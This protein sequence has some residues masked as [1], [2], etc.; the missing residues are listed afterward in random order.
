MRIAMFGGSFNPVHIGHRQLAEAFAKELKL[1][2][3]IVMPAY[4]SPF[5]QSDHSI[6]PQQRYEMC[7]L[8]FE[9]MDKATVSDL[10]ISREGSSYTYMTLLELQKQFPL[11][12]LFLIT[13]AD[14]FLT[15][16]RWKNP[17][18][19]FRTATVCGVP[20]ND[21]DIA[22]LQQYADYLQTLGAKAIVLDTRVMTVSSTQVRE[23][24]RNGAD[25][26]DLVAPKVKEY[27]L[28]H[29]LYR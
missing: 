29:Q 21:D 9:D 16:E 24:V 22:Q 8:A 1:D 13:G 4:V 6:T 11:S 10:E 7:R 23:A 17:D 28:Q 25:I 19:I 3:L 26:S 12:E 14:M 5:K 20:R 2:R 18:V 27:I 15:L